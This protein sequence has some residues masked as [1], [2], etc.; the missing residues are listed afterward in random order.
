MRRIESELEAEDHGIRKPTV[1]EK[2]EA[3]IASAYASNDIA[4]A[5]RVQDQ[6]DR[7]LALGRVR[8]QEKRLRKRNVK[9]GPARMEAWP[10][11]FGPNSDNDLIA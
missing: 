1:K 4:K 5:K 7:K 3:A 11:K 10:K 8:C 6:L 9:R 2:L